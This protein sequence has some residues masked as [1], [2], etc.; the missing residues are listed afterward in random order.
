MNTKI[1]YINIFYKKREKIKLIRPLLNLNRFEIIKLC[2]FWKLPIYV[3]LTNKYINLKRNRL[4]H[5]ILPTLKIFFNSK[6]QKALVHCIKTI[7]FENTYFKYQL[8]SIKKFL[9][10]KHFTY[11]KIRGKSHLSKWL[12]YLPYA[13]QQKVYQQ[14]LVFHFKSLTFLEIQFFLK[15]ILFFK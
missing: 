11:T 6:I 5:Q 3:D 4:R 10:T 15:N 9:K 7:Q 14:F 8:K 1:V 2:N 12:R 13:L